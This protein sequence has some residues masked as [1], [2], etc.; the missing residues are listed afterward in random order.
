[1]YN[2]DYI[3][4]IQR[5]YELAYKLVM[6]LVGIVQLRLSRFSETN[7]VDGSQLVQPAQ[8]KA[9][10]YA[11]DNSKWDYQDEGTKDLSLS[12]IDV[13]H[14]LPVDFNKLALVWK[15]V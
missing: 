2:Q 12:L 15:A 7:I 13:M 1:M 11:R 9:S 5:F 10:H 14:L 3:L 6:R 8:H 4:Q